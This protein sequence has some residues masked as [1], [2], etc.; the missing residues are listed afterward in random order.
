M[1]VATT[2]NASLRVVDTVEGMSRS[3]ANSVVAI[4]GAS[5]GLG[6]QFVEQLRAEGAQLLLAGPHPERL[7]PLCGPGDVV[8]PLDLRD[9]RAGDT[10]AGV[11]TELGRLDGVINAA[12]VVA[13]GGLAELDDVILEELFL[14][15]VL[16]PLWLTKRVAP[17]LSASNGWL[18][19]ISGV[20]AESPLPNM[21]AYS[22]AKAAISAANRALHRELRRQNIFVCDARPPHTETGL[23]TRALAGTAPRFPPGAQPSAVAAR[24]LQGVRDGVPEL[25]GADFA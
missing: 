6:T 13:F 1:L 5:G 15:D 21:A 9:A 24:I 10:L 7:T 23:A 20:I 3:F 11:A 25:A 18:V 19:H 2:P 17:L 4:V 12:G 16:G 22:A 8:V 14:I